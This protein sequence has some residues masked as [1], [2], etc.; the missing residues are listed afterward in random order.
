MIVYYRSFGT[1]IQYCPETLLLC[2]LAI[3]AY[4]DYLLIIFASDANT[5]LFSLW[6]VWQSGVDR[7]CCVLTWANIKTPEN[8]TSPFGRPV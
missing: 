5:L 7:F 4:M 2:D 3:F 1:T 6:F 8:T